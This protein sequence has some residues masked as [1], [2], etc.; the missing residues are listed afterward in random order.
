[1]EELPSTEPMKQKVL[2]PVV[3][4]DSYRIRV[5]QPCWFF[6]KEPFHNHQQRTTS[7]KQEEQE[8]ASDIKER[9]IAQVQWLYYHQEKRSEAAKLATELIS[10]GEIGGCKLTRTEIAEIEDILKHC[11]T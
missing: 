9:A 6:M 4:D 7:G 10:A 8:L 2:P 5:E 1:M 11:T 3:H